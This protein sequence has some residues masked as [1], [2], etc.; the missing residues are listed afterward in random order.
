MI[1]IYCSKVEDL[2]SNFRSD[3]FD[4]CLCDPPYGLKFMGKSWD[5]GVPS[6]AIWKLVKRTLKPGAPILAFGGTRTYHRLAC[7]IEDAGFEIFDSILGAA[8]IY[9][10]GFPKSLD[11]SKAIDKAAG[12]EREKTGTRIYGDGHIQRSSLDKL[13]PPIG[14]FKRTQDLRATSAPATDHAQLWDGY[15][16]ALKPA[17]EPIV[18]AR[19]PLSGT[20]AENCIEHG[21]GGLNIDGSRIGSDTARGDRY[22]GKPPGG[23]HSMQIAGPREKTWQVPAGRYPANLILSHH[24]DCS[25][26][27]TRRVPPRGGDIKPNSKGAGPRSNQV[28]GQDAS[29]RGE[30]TAYKGEDG[31]EEIEAWECCPECPVAALDKQSGLLHTQDPATRMRKTRVV[32]KLHGSRFVDDVGKGAGYGDAGGAS[33]FFHQSAW[34]PSE[35]LEMAY[36]AKVSTAERNRGLPAGVVCDHPTLKPIE[37]CRYLATLILPPPRS[38]TQPRNL[39]VPFSG[40]GSEIIGA[41]LA[42]WE[43]ITAIEKEENYIEQACYRIKGRTGIEA[44][45]W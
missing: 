40:A 25:P 2:L 12:V 21:C 43:S 38:V 44:T 32:N 26:L 17:W 10:Q 14:T 6:A 18:F 28:Y 27:G 19:K 29:D 24:P 31:L 20:Y 23:S 30:W 41:T 7:A 11:I 35:L 42:G 15:G 22:Y 45:L 39:L 9:G 36:H 3:F 13:A 16:T 4:A 8:W 37:L 33:R 5:H 1:S 34:A